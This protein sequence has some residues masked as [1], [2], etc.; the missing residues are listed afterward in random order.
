MSAKPIVYA[1]CLMLC[2]VMSGCNALK[3]D[4]DLRVYQCK[5]DGVETF[6]SG[7]VA[8]AYQRDG[9]LMIPG[10][11]MYRMQPGEFCEVR[12]PQK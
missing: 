8:N 3:Y 12:V 2:V 4:P 9:T 1:V 10:R 7:V 6:Y 5:K 11:G